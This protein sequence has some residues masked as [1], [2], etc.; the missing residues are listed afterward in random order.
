M[1]E[2]AGK[3]TVPSDS[4]PRIVLN[5]KSP[6]VIDVILSIEKAADEKGEGCRH[7]NRA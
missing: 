4:K 7:N 2:I 5:E 6:A 1:Q 3:E